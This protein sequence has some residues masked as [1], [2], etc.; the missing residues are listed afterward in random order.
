[1]G[2]LLILRR[3]LRRLRNLLCWCLRTGFIFGFIFD[4][5][6]AGFIFDLFDTGKSVDFAIDCI[7]RSGECLMVVLNAINSC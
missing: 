7:N 4:L 1:M 3:R 2:S 6:D 5:L